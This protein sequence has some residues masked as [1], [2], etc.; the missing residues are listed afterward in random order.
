MPSVDGWRNSIS[1]R[2]CVACNEITR[3]WWLIEH[4]CF[5]EHLL[6]WHKDALPDS[7]VN[8]PHAPA[9]AVA[10]T[11][12]DISDRH[13]CGKPSAA[14][15]FFQLKIATETQ[16]YCYYIVWLCELFDENAY[17]CFNE[18]A[19]CYVEIAYVVSLPIKWGTG[20][21]HS[22]Y[23]ARFRINIDGYR[24]IRSVCCNRTPSNR[25]FGN[26]W[27]RSSRNNTPGPG[28][29]VKCDCS[30][31]HAAPT[32]KTLHPLCLSQA[33]DLFVFEACCLVSG[34]PFSGTHIKR[35]RLHT[36]D[37]RMHW[38]TI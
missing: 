11:S 27:S 30:M 29:L 17:F 16:N 25:V 34:L 21:S 12:S 9:S 19:Y 20:S 18:S 26:A 2:C 8:S 24:V 37:V 31:H 14:D 38:C 32:D 33:A 13:A 10:I 3:T 22:R 36:V 7:S 5:T 4:A 6:T 15:K 1:V 35:A 28:A 23:D